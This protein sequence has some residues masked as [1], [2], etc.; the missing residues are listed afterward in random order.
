[1]DLEHRYICETD[2]GHSHGRPSRA[3]VLGHSARRWWQVKART[4]FVV[5]LLLLCAIIVD[6]DFVLEFCML[7]RGSRGCCVLKTRRQIREILLLLGN[8]CGYFICDEGSVFFL[9]L[10]FL[11]FFFLGRSEHFV[12][13]C[14]L[15]QNR[16]IV[17]LTFCRYIHFYWF[18][19]LQFCLLHAFCSWTT[20]KKKELLHQSRGW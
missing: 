19:M 12:F 3:F 18:L 8:F 13:L 9:P 4:S 1:V 15:S 7:C 16:G 2:N 14:N 20:G 6:F 10:L 11:G 17:C 5:R